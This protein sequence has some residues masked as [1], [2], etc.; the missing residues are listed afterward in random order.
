[1]GVADLLATLRRRG[2]EVRAADG[3]LV[4]TSSAPLCDAV[5]RELR[6][7]KAPLLRHLQPTTLWRLADGTVYA[8]PPES[9]I[10]A[11]IRTG[12]PAE[13]LYP[14]NTCAHR[15]RPGLSDEGY[16]AGRSDLPRAY[17]ADSTHPLRQL[18]ADGG[19]NCD[20]WEPRA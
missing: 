4:I 17:G 7:C 16:C 3:D 14:C 13:A 9:D 5:R 12:Q 6:E 19:V 11:S 2:I 20:A 18:P 10:E 8:G 1:M 15:A